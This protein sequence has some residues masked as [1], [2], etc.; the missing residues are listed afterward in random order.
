MNDLIDRVMRGE[1]TPEEQ[2]ELAAW[3]SATVE[4]EREYQEVVALLRTLRD[5]TPS[6]A[7]HPPRAVDLIDR[8]HRRREEAGRERRSMV[9]RWLPWSVAAAA[10]IVAVTLGWS[11]YTRPPMGSWQPTEIVTGAGELATV[12]LGDGSVA[13]LAPRSRLRMMPSHG[14]R[15]VWLEGHAFFAVAKQHGRAFRVRT[16]GGDALALGTRFDVATHARGLRLAVLDGRVELSAGEGS[17]GIEVGDGQSAGLIEGRPT[18]ATRITDRASVVA[19]MGRFLAFQSTPL[20]R[21]RDEIER[22]YGVRVVVSDSALLNE[23]VSASFTD[24]PF[25]QTVGV[26]CAVIGGHCAISDSA[27]IISR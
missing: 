5:V 19:W 25:Q 12:Q 27:V 18:P 21:V 1:A 8:M 22:M 3:R 14:E 7:V 20:S 9:T 26:V 4:N 17:K 11:T 15:L 16:R 2:A 24:E 6:K 13:R 23:T 10:V